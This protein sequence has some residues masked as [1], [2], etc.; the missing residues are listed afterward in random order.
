MSLRSN[1]LPKQGPNPKNTGALTPHLHNLTLKIPGIMLLIAARMHT[2]KEKAPISQNKNQIQRYL[3]LALQKLFMLAATSL[4]PPA[5]FRSYLP[6]TEL[7]AWQ[8]FNAICFYSEQPGRCFRAR[9]EDGLQVHRLQEARPRAH[10]LQR[11]DLPPVIEA[12]TFLSRRALISSRSP[13]YHDTVPSSA[14]GLV[15]PEALPSST[16]TPLLF[17]AQGRNCQGSQQG[18]RAEEQLSELGQTPGLSFRENLE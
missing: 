15:F 13:A 11:P 2:L 5:K 17:S 12:S 6:Q 14:T 16:N 1:C 4:L 7:W 10:Q 3:T 9:C 8:H 18:K